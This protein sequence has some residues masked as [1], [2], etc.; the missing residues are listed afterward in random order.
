V[1]QNSFCDKYPITQ[2]LY[3]PIAGKF[4]VYNYLLS[5]SPK[6]RPTQQKGT[7]PA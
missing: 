5:L 2:K 4:Y 7:I 6:K 3:L 1:L